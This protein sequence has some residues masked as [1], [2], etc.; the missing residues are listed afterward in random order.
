MN[1]SKPHMQNSFFTAKDTPLYNDG[2]SYVPEYK[3]PQKRRRIIMTIQ[4]ITTDQEDSKAHE[5]HKEPFR[6]NAGQAR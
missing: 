4:G 2:A 6:R 1:P 3:I 5:F